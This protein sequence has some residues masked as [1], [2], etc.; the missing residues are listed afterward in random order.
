MDLKKTKLIQLLNTFSK[1]EMREFEKFLNMSFLTSE[2]NLE[3]LFNI[4]NKF[5]GKFDDEKFNSQDIYKSLFGTKKF[6]NKYLTSLM[7]DL[8]KTAKYF[9]VVKEVY[10][11]EVL[12]NKIIC[13]E[14]LKRD[15]TDEFERQMKS[16]I[17]TLEKNYSTSKNYNNDRYDLALIN[18]SYLDSQKD[19]EEYKNSYLNMINYFFLDT[20]K[21]I[22]SFYSEIYI[23]KEQ[24]LISEEKNIT[25]FVFNKLNY[26]EILNLMNGVSV[27]QKNKLRIFYLCSVLME[28]KSMELYEEVKKLFFE[29]YLIFGTDERREIYF[30]LI[31]FC[32]YMAVTRD[33]LTLEVFNIFN[34]F[35]S[36]K[37]KL[38]L[39]NN[40]IDRRLF[41]NIVLC[42][43][44][45]NKN[46]WVIE[47]INE[48]KKYLKPDQSDNLENYLLAMAYS[49]V[50][51]F[52]KSLEILSKVKFNYGTFKEDILLLK[53]TVLFEK[54]FILEALETIISFKKTFKKTSAMSK[55][56]Y[57]YYKN[58]IT[59]L[60]KFYNAVL[61]QNIKELEFIEKSVM[62]CE[63]LLVK[64]W[65][66]KKIELHKLNTGKNGI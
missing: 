14:F 41:R 19:F 22:S 39:Q 23:F 38:F 31:N 24:N 4:L 59:F 58:S 32:S 18:S 2:R 65:L 44:Q 37:D 47:F 52:D 57:E 36:D 62:E 6:S 26:D 34:K 50:R 66:L 8:Y 33:D 29:R 10:T 25:E 42:A 45:L 5:H 16:S 11:N 7:S 56:I 30:A 54:G 35:L 55:S 20:L 51:E 17:D 1:T 27:D 53:S 64:P 21:K 12:F 43:T 3:P 9:L 61:K 63:Y 48:H 28:K 46:D 49:R 13:K 60:I 15:L 40:T